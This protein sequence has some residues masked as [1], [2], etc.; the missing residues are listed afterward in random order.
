[1]GSAPGPGA[2][3]RVPAPNSDTQANQPKMPSAR[4]PMAAPGT[5]ALPRAAVLPI[6]NPLFS[7]RRSETKADSILVFISIR[8]QNVKVFDDGIVVRHH[9]S[10]DPIV[11]NNVKHNNIRQTAA[12]AHDGAGGDFRHDL[13]IRDHAEIDR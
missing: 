7:S 12:K 10:A 2:V 13:I 4:T 11:V 6:L 9:G 1:M 5:G 8:R 3:R